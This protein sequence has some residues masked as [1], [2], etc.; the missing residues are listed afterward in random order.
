ML[1]VMAILYII[2]GLIAII[3]PESAIRIIGILF[4]LSGIYLGLL[5]YNVIHPWS[6]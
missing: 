2:F 3:W 6:M 4:V 1:I 5:N